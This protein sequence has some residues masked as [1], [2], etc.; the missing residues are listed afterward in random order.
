[1]RVSLEGVVKQLTHSKPGTRHYHPAVSPNHRWVLYGSDCDGAMQLY[2]AGIDGGGAKRIT[3]VSDGYCA[4]H[5]MWRK[6]P[7]VP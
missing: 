6:V 5:G 3:N 7:D 1:M 2:V 4:M